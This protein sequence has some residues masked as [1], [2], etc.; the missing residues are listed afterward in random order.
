MQKQSASGAS[1][2]LI[3]AKEVSV[4]TSLSTPRIYQLVKEGS[5]PKPLQISEKRVAWK[6]ADVIG[7]IDSQQTAAWAQ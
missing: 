5:F 7:W 4:L 1:R 3:K 6:E 2:R